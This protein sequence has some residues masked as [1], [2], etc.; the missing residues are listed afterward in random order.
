MLPFP[1]VDLFNPSK[2]MLSTLDKKKAPLLLFAR[3]YSTHTHTH[4]HICS[5][6]SRENGLSCRREK[7][8]RI[9]AGNEKK[10]C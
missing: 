2:I 4:T 10:K 5:T 1:C 8:I 9:Q 6:V 3:L 7:K